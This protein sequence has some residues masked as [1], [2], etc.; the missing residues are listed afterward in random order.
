MTRAHARHCDRLA[1]A[2]QPVAPPFSATTARGS[3]LPL[4][5]RRRASASGARCTIDGLATPQPGK[6]GN[7]RNSGG[8]GRLCVAHTLRAVELRRK[9]TLWRRSDGSVRPG[10]AVARLPAA[11]RRRPARKLMTRRLG[12]VAETYERGR[13][14][15]LMRAARMLSAAGAIGA[16]LPAGRSRSRARLGPRPQVHR[17]PTARPYGRTRPKPRISVIRR[18]RPS[19]RA[20]GS[21]PGRRRRRGS[22][23]GRRRRGS[24]SAR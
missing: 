15:R 21:R 8:P 11:E 3:D 24:P 19:C 6:R 20:R 22:H 13:S 7:W 17:S 23:P 5:G 2:S 10:T 18:T 14:G 1:V 4:R 16:A 9:V 12:P